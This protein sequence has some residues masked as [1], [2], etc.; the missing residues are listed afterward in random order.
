MVVLVTFDALRADAV[1][2][3]VEPG[4]PTPG[5]AALAGDSIVFTQAI[6]SYQGTTA[7][8]AS[9]MTGRWPSFE[10]LDSMAPDTLYGFWHLKDPDEQ[11]RIWL[12]GNVTTLAEILSSQGW[13]TAGFNTNPYLSVSHNFHQGFQHYE[14]FLNYLEAERAHRRHEMEPAYPPAP[15]VF[16]K[17]AAWIESHASRPLLAW[18]HI[19]DPHSPYLPPAEFDRGWAAPPTPLSDLDVNRALYHL[20]FARRGDTAQAERFPSHD[21]HEVSRESLIEHARALYRAEV[22]HS[23]RELG[24]FVDRLR[25][26]GVLDRAIL[27]VTADHGEEFDDHGEIFHEMRQPGYEELL[28]VP[29]LIRLP[30][31]RLGGRVVT[32]QTRLLD[33][34]PTLLE[35][36]DLDGLEHE[37]DGLSMV[38][39]LDVDIAEDRPYFMSSPGYGIVRLGQWKYK[40]G[41]GPALVERLHDLLADPAEAHNLVAARPEVAAELRE[42]YREFAAD[43]ARRSTDQKGSEPVQQTVIDAATR[44]QL[45]ILG[46]S[47]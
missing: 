11:G 2:Y 1:C 29:M 8:M 20:L 35:L 5:F 46:Y 42:R 4:C 7:S 47:E 17:A 19:M 27:V 16:D 3:S 21:Q 32:S 39:I 10:G 37:F 41:K 36:L 40:F 26:T 15:V 31:G 45:A 6:S 24:R 38:D 43:M 13:Q 14:Q 9:L 34:V 28:H 18:L 44:E 23:D 12:T 30:N 33:I 25:R 22:A